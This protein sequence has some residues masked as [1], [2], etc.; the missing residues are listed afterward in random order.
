MDLIAFAAIAGLAMVF[1]AYFFFSKI[2]ELYIIARV[3]AA[4]NKINYGQNY[5]VRGHYYGQMEGGKP[6]GYGTFTFVFGP[7]AGDK[8]MGEW[9]K[10]KDGYRYGLYTYAN[11]NKYVGEMK[12]YKRHGQGTLTL[13]NGTIKHSG[14]WFYDS[15]KSI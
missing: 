6:H 2:R 14:K 15:P 13:A 9:K 8:Y 11:G 10:N 5:D 3:K 12:D 1:L 7:S 4:G